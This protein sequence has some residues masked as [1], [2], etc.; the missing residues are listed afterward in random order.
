VLIGGG[1]ERSAL[2]ALAAA[3]GLSDRARFTGARA[4]ARALLPAFDVAVV[5]STGREGMPLAA[6]EAIDAGLPLVASRLG[7][8]CEV[9]EHERTGLL[10]PPGDV[11]ALAAALRAVLEHPGRGR[12]LGEA[13][14]RSVE[15][16]FR[17]GL[18]ARRIE[19]IE[20]EALHV[21]FAA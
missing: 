7:G 18:V 12:G 20:E 16:N 8:L 9:V 21:R 13:A 2:E 14:R 10:V 1:P 3:C 4:D 5:P 19:A 17:A 11:G 6:L 15:A